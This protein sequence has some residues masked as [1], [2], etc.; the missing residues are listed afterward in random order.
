MSPVSPET[1]QALALAAAA[2]LALWE[3]MTR[4]LRA[5]LMSVVMIGLISKEFHVLACFIALGMV[6][7][8]VTQERWQKPHGNDNMRAF[9]ALAV[10]AS[11]VAIMT[12]YASGMPVELQHLLSWFEAFRID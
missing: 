9:L 4:H 1:V 5:A 11:N 3:G 12:M 2:G 8:V 6:L 10:L 7:P